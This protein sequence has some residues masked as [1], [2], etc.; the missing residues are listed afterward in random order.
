MVEWLVNNEWERIRFETIIVSFQIPSWHIRWNSEENYDLNHWKVCQA[1][2]WNLVL[3]L[4]QNVQCVLSLTLNKC[5]TIF[6]ITFCT[7]CPR[8]IFMCFVWIWEQTAIISLYSINWLFL[9]NRDGVCLLRGQDWISI[10]NSMFCLESVFMCFVW[11][12]EQTAIISLYSINWLV[13]YNRD[14]LRLLR[15]TNCVVVYNSSYSLL[16]V[17]SCNL[18]RDQHK[19]WLTAWMTGWLPGWMNVWMTECW[20]AD[21]RVT[22]SWL[23]L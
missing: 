17:S 12:W 5:T 11:V 22:L 18:G 4:R 20:P 7:F 6:N 9:F 19:D 23:R 10:Y 13:C 21:R 8:T 16:L 15:G 1:R 3:L 14:G 2:A